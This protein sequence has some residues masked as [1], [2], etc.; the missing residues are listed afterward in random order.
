MTKCVGS[1]WNSNKIALSDTYNAP[2][3][4][5]NAL[6]KNSISSHKIK[7]N[8]NKIYMRM[9]IKQ[10]S[11]G[12]VNR[13]HNAIEQNT[14]TNRHTHQIAR[15]HSKFMQWVCCSRYCFFPVIF[16]RPVNFKSPNLLPVPKK[17][18]NAILMLRIETEHVWIRQ[19]LQTHIHSKPRANGRLRSITLPSFQKKIVYLVNRQ[20]SQVKSYAIFFV[21]NAKQ[22]QEQRP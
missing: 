15:K 12:S 18:P 8:S 7:E 6:A 10:S 5:T 13:R 4:T 19:N 17:I 14:N 20:K 1:T 11:A 22:P 9:N 3:M 21:L 2:M 16:V